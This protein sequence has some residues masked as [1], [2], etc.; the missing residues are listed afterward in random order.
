MLKKVIMFPFIH[1]NYRCLP[2]RPRVP[3]GGAAAAANRGIV[4]GCNR[5]AVLGLAARF[6]RDRSGAYA[7][8]FG[9]MAPIF[10]GTLTLGTETGLW[11]KT[12]EKMQGAADSAAISAAVGLNAGNTNLTL[13]ADAVAASYKFVNGS[14]GTTVTVNQPPLSGP[15]VATPGAVEVIIN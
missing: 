14:S 6:M 10:L 3:R 1:K 4:T 8:M 2:S 7:V 9:L 13:Q 12:Q 15:N 11:Y 5:L